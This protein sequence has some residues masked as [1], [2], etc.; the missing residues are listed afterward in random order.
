MV[1]NKQKWQNQTISCWILSCTIRYFQ[2]AD[3]IV[4]ETNSLFI[5]GYGSC[6]PLLRN[7]PT[8]NIR[9]AITMRSDHTFARPYCL[10][11]GFRMSA[12]VLQVPC[13]I[14]VATLCHTIFFLCV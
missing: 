11:E 7:I 4:G 1:Q 12:Q 2:K 8:V 10:D 9:I 3:V 13:K 14:H 6:I 5:Y